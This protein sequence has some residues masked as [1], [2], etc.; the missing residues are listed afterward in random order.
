MTNFIFSLDLIHLCNTNHNFS[1][2]MPQS[3]NTN[4]IDLN[5][6]IKIWFISPLSIISEH[7]FF[8]IRILYNLT[9]TQMH[10]HIQM[11]DLTYIQSHIPLII[12][13]SNRL[14]PS[15]VCTFK[16]Q[17]ILALITDHIPQIT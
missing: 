5:K 10:S 4:S 16:G 8:A 13:N 11:F 15:I 2:L 12:C 17:K 9:Y 14:W 1:I 7:P 6:K 3:Y